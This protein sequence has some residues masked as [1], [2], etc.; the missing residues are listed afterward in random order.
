MLTLLGVPVEDVYR[1]YLLTNDQLIPALEPIVTAF[2]LAGGDP[3]QLWPGLGVDRAYLDG[4][5]AGGDEAYGTIAAYFAD[6]LGLDEQA[7]DELRAR[8]LTVTPPAA[9]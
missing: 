5:F 4:A 9:S 8:Y 7:Q 6:G 1:E 2:A 3:D